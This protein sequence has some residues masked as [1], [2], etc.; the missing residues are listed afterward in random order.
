MRCLSLSLL[1]AVVSLLS[2][3]ETE[4]TEASLHFS[5]LCTSF[6]IHRERKHWGYVLSLYE[7]GKWREIMSGIMVHLCLTNGLKEGG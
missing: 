4:E 3:K 7:G 1:S 5:V 2:E 6:F